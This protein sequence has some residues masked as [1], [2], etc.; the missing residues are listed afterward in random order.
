MGNTIPTEEQDQETHST[1]TEVYEL[2]FFSKILHKNAQ[3]AQKN[4]AQ[5]ENF[6]KIKWKVL[7]R[8]HGVEE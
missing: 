7:N 2:I 4:N 1:K 8:N 3:W 5:S 6:K